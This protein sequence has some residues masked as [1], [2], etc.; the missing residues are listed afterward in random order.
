M[1]NNNFNF[2]LYYININGDIKSCI[3]YFIRTKNFKSHDRNILII[4][5]VSKNHRDRSVEEVT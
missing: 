1:T 5:H 4:N 2:K 3:F